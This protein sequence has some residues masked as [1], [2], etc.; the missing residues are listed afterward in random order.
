M[1]ATKRGAYQITQHNTHDSANML[2]HDDVIKMETRYWPQVREIHR[3][4]VNSLTKASD[5]KMFVY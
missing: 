2:Y 4:P 5:A 3:S 1:P